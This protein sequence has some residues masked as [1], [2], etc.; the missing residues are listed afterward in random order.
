MADK[1]TYKFTSNALKKNSLSLISK[2]LRPYL[3]YTDIPST[4][5]REARTLTWTRC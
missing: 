2:A 1:I 5:N 3:I 4:S